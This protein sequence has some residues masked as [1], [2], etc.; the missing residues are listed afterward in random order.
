MNETIETNAG[1]WD[2]GDYERNARFVSDYGTKLLGWLAPCSD[3]MILDIGC[4]DGAITARIAASGAQVVG[5]DGSAEMVAAARKRGLNVDMADA[6]R[7]DKIPGMG[8]MF[9]AVFSNAALHWMRDDPQAVIEAVHACLRPGGR[10]VAEMGAAG[11]VAPIVAALRAEA[12]ARGLDPDALDPWYFPTETAYLDRLATAG[13]HIE[14]SHCFERPTQLPGDIS[15]W[16]TTLARP[17]TTAFGEGAERA[18][19][20]AAVRERLANELPHHDGQWIA[21][22]VRLRFIARK[23]DAT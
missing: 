23:P 2:A 19:Y 6:Q 9:D 22:Y 5:L 16:L 13:F 10:F 17:F 4:G 12:D 15:D 18:A 11:N 8:N 21:P 20:I 14:R 1:G 7:L 3:E